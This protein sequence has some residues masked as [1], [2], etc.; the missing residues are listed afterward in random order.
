MAEEV[1]PQVHAVRLRVADLDTN[2][3]PLPG[4]GHLYVSGAL[5]TL[6]MSP[7]Y[8]DGA[9][10]EEPNGTGEVCV[11]YQGRPSFKRLDVS[12]EL[13]TPDPY[14]DKILERGS[15]LAAGGGRPPGY[16][17]PEFGPLGGN[18]VSIEV[19]ARRVNDGDM[20]PDY[21]YAWWT[22]PKVVNLRPGD[23]EIGNS[24]QKPTKSGNAVQNPNW[25][26]GPANDWP[27]AS[28]RAAQWVPCTAAEMPDAHTGPLTLPVS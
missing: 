24:A 1:L 19:W 5:T 8:R 10:V 3:V 22:L 17:L 25:F 7:Q 9:E 28:D 12:L 4:A 13:C 26:D 2:G 6:S 21:P 20:D 15:V 23:R 27:V 18:G 16:A 14:L 11:Y